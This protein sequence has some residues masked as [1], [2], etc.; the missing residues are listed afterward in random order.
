MIADKDELFATV[1]QGNET[2]VVSEAVELG[3]AHTSN[4]SSLTAHL[5]SWHWLASSTRMWQKEKFER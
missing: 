2:T 5:S 4:Y 1:D 3:K